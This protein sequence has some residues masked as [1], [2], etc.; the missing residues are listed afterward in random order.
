MQDAWAHPPASTE[1]V[2]HP[3]KFF[4]HEA[5]RAVPL[6]WSPE[7]SALVSSGVLGELYTRTLLGEGSDA[8]AAGWGGDAYRTWDARGRTLLVWRSVWD[9]PADAAEFATALRARYQAGAR[10]LGTMG[11][12]SRYERDG[13]ERAVLLRDGVVLLVG[14]DDKTLLLKA[15]AA[16]SRP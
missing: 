9:T 8:A 4:A 5:P 16:L 14:S 10:D 13:F 1:Q 6:D 3:E 7:G 12:F 11:G 15:M 2:L